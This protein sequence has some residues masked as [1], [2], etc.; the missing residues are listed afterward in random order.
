MSR[1]D[2]NG[3]RTDLVEDLPAFGDH[4]TNHMVLKE[5]KVY[6]GQGTVTNTA[7][8]G[9]DNLTLFGWLPKHPEGHDTPAYDVVLNGTNYRALNPLKPI[10]TV[11][12][13]PYL[14]LGTPGHDGQVIKGALR[15]NGVIYT[16][17]S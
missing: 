2:L 6:F 1:V 3:T 11:E 16:H 14:P 7:I 17:R 10:E 13:G 5:G 4:H 12:T 8:V 9:A 15:S